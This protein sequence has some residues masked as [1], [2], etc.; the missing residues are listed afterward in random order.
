MTRTDEY[1]IVG[2]TLILLAGVI[3]VTCICWGA[4][5]KLANECAKRSK[6]ERYEITYYVAGT[7]KK[8]LA[9]GHCRPYSDG[10]GVL[11]FTDAET[12]RGY[13]ISGE[14]TVVRIK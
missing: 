13:Q 9:N 11:Y 7:Q 4:G 3:C 2:S 6:L 10:N 14:Y 1:K 12:G 8:Y 5:L